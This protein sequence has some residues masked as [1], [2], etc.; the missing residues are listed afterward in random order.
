M[1]P[2]AKFLAAAVIFLAGLA[3]FSRLVSMKEAP[4]LI[5]GLFD[6]L[7]NF[8]RGAFDQ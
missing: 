5:K 4:G 2:V 6:T 1:K 7:T 3:V 8:F